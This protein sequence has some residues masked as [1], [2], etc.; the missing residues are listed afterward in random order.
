MRPTHH[1]LAVEDHSKRKG[2]NAAH[3]A[4]NM[5][6]VNNKRLLLLVVA[7]CACNK[8][9]PLDSDAA[10]IADG[11]IV[12]VDAGPVRG[13]SE[14]FIPTFVV[15]YAGAATNL[16]SAAETAKFDLLIVSPSHH[17]SW[18]ESGFSNSWKTLRSYNPDIVIALYAYGATR[19]N[20]VS[21]GELGL[22]WDWM[23]ANH[24]ANA[25]AN[26]WTGSGLAYP[27]LTN[28]QYPN[29]RFMNL[30]HPDWQDYWWR[31]LYTDYWQG[32]KSY[33]SDGADAIFADVMGYKIGYPGGW[34]AE[35]HAGDAAYRDH[36]ADYYD[37]GTYDHAQF[38]VDANAFFAKAVPGLASHQIALVPN[39]GG[40][41]DA[42]DVAGWLELDQQPAPPFGA[43]AE[44][45]FVQS[46]GGTYNTF[47]FRTKVDAMRQLKN[48]AA[49][50][51]CKGVVSSGTGLAKMDVVMNGG[52][53]GPTTGWQ[54][55]WYSFTSLLMGLNPERT[56][57]YVGFTVWGYS[58]YHWFDEFDPKFLHFGN[59]VGEYQQ[60]GAVYLREYDDGWVVVN[61]STSNATVTVP[62][63]AG[64]VLD[65][66]TFKNP[67]TS[68]LVTQFTL[69][70]HRGVLV[71]K[72]GRNVGNA[73]NL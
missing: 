49:V 33:D 50:F 39:F 34:Y 36:P 42:Q 45:G 69:P 51:M 1:T 66:A 32:G 2:T 25:G 4:M 62:S 38:Q 58:E 31:T 37:N 72:E 29:D 56:N 65:H 21:W 52:N 22:G 43:M 47:A 70:A 26:R 15:K 23:K 68:P 54:A 59:A 20:A 48:T 71:L 28:T 9:E 24:G 14:K 57:G 12:E 18:R 44:A 6:L 53:M 19:Y 11:H 67:M 41:N 5:K 10:T 55:L 46:Y 61:P 64:R 73:D 40:M 27:Y 13:P 7:L 35:G 60:V 8:P 30:G 17:M 16:L 3:I 63:G